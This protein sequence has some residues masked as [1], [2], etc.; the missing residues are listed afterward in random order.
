MGQ[1]RH[2]LSFDVECHY[3][4]VWK[5][6]LDAKKVPTVEVERNTDFLLDLLDQK[7]TKATF[8]TLGNVAKRYPG[9]VRRIV[10]E[11][12][13]IG[14][15]GYD[16]HYINRMSRPSFEE[17]VRRAVG[18]LEEVGGARVR[19]H[20]APAFSIGKGNLWALD[21]LREQGLDYDSSIFPIKGR[22]YGVP[23]APMTIHRL[24]NGLFEVPLTALTIGQRRVPAAGGG[25]FRLFPAGYT[26]WAVERCASEGRPAITYFHPH[27]FELTRAR[28]GLEGWKTSIRGG[29]RMLRVNTMQSLGRGRSMRRK[30]SRLLDG[31]Q[32]SPICDLLPS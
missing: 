8:F 27:E 7:L 21:V 11:G 2:G 18:I 31:H 4:I 22:R 13:E 26:R 9:L 5:D 28:V 17:E 12:H 24:E 32:F 3:Q 16:H 29:L 25:Y 23:D 10:A 20:R 15:H 1:L 19:G 6:C 30:L 14:V